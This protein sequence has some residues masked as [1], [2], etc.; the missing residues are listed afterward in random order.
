[1]DF[2]NQNTTFDI[3]RCGFFEYSG[4]CAA[5]HFR[6]QQL[7]ISEQ[8][9]HVPAQDHT[10]TRAIGAASGLSKYTPL[11]KSKNLKSQYAP[12]FDKRPLCRHAQL[13]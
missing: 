6:E 2:R 9:N 7:K 10:R 11:F 3:F 8:Q 13:F 1:M 5:V 4:F 12:I